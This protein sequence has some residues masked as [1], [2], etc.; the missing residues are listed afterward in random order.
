M[1]V[2]SKNLSNLLRIYL[3]R[4]KVKVECSNFVREIIFLNLIG[5][6]FNLNLKYQSWILAIFHNKEIDTLASSTTYFIP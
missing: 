6:K 1:D 5:L 2:S 4:D 3:R